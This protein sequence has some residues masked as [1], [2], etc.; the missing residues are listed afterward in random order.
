[1]DQKLLNIPK[2]RPLKGTTKKFP[3][4]FIGDEAFPLKDYLIKPNP[5]SSL[6]LNEKI[7]NY[8]ISLAKRQVENVFGICASRFRVLRRPIIAKVD[9]ITSIT[10]SVTA[11]HN[12]FMSG[13]Q[14][15][16][17]EEYCPVGYAEGHWRNYNTETDGPA[18]LIHTDSNNYSRDARQVRDNFRDYF[19]SPC[20]SVKWQWDAVNRTYDAFDEN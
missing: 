11:L 15:G 18:P 17:Y 8:R 9:T 3:F 2:P 16:E 14:F 12:Y 5:K 1:M 4:V 7:A 19:N 6:Q 20:G 10:E 13:R